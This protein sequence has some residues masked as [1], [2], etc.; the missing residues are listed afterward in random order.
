MI[1]NY[2]YYKKTT[3][4][5]MHTK[6][7]EFVTACFAEDSETVIKRREIFH[8][9]YTETVFYSTNTVHRFVITSRA[10]RKAGEKKCWFYWVA[11]ATDT[12]TQMTSEY[13][14]CKDE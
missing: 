2:R 9:G 8:E 3:A 14:T 4:D 5:F 11:P 7:Y 1:Y 10:D 13:Y 12:G 6:L